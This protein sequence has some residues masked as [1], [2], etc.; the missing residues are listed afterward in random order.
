MF[1]VKWIPFTLLH[2]I[3][4]IFSTEKVELLDRIS[5]SECQRPYHVERTRSRQL[6][7]VKLHRVPLVLGWVTA[8]EYGMPL[9][10]LF[11]FFFD[12]SSILFNQIRLIDFILFQGNWLL[13]PSAFSLWITIPYIF[14]YFSLK[15]FEFS[16][17]SNRVYVNNISRQALVFTNMF[18]IF[19]F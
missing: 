8:W 1:T 2:E 5:P 10:Y 18:F 15:A 17:H 7:A 14:L 13:S 4:T 9:A 16:T 11:N 19:D 6:P 12:R 3:K